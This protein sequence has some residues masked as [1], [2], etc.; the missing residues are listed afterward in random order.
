MAAGRARASHTAS[1]GDISVIAAGLAG[2]VA[3]L[4]LLRLANARDRRAADDRAPP[5]CA[6]PPSP[7][8]YAP[9][10]VRTAAPILLAVGLALVGVGLAFGSGG[11]AL[12]IRPVLPGVVVL[13]AA[14]VALVRQGGHTSPPDGPSADVNA[15]G[16]GSDHVAAADSHPAVPGENASRHDR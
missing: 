13:L 12:D 4:L 8:G 3:G 14:L 7:T 15:T 1:M 2:A 10:A 5:G 11:G 16:L 6:E 9:R